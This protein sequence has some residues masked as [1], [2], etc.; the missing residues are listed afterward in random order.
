MQHRVSGHGKGEAMTAV[1]KRALPVPP[2]PTTKE[3]RYVEPMAAGLFNAFEWDVEKGK[4][5]RAKSVEARQK[6]ARERARE[7]REHNHPRRVWTADDIAEIRRLRAAGV[8]WRDIAEKFDVSDTSV[9]KA[10][11]R[12]EKGER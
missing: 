9:K 4:R 5:A 1:I 7:S 10:L 12:N 3:Y 6:R 8:I 2:L 11:E